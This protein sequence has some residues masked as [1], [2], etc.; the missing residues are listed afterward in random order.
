M[1]PIVVDAEKIRHDLM[2]YF[3]ASNLPFKMVAVARVEVATPDEVID[4]ALDEGFDID[5]YAVN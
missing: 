5:K 3:G 4:L 2:D 1:N